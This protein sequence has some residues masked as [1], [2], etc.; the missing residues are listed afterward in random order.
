MG[1]ILPRAES[2]KPRTVIDQLAPQEELQVEQKREL[3]QKQ[4]GTV[5]VLVLVRLSS[6]RMPSTMTMSAPNFGCTG[7]LLRIGGIPSL[8][9]RGAESKTR[10]EK[11]VQLSPT[12]S[13]QTKGR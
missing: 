12:A 3:Q 9:V 2:E 5:P 11:S 10:D 13:A 4:E 7:G 1:T 6:A 8:Q